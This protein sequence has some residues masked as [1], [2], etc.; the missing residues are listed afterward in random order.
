M[1]RLGSTCGLSNMEDEI[2]DLRMKPI[3]VFT[4]KMKNLRG[5][6]SLLCTCKKY[7]I[8]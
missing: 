2:N 7:T 8:T 5:L 1:K 4:S 6:F 3:D